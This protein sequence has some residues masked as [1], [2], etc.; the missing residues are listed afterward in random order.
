MNVNPSLFYLH[1]LLPLFMDLCR[2]D[3]GAQRVC[4]LSTYMNIYNRVLART[5]LKQGGISV[6]HI[7]GNLGACSPSNF[8]QRQAG[9]DW[10]VCFAGNSCFFPTC[11]ASLRSEPELPVDPLEVSP[12]SLR[13]CTFSICRQRDCGDTKGMCLFNFM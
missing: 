8:I 12:Q 1:R 4:G 2:S 13:L 10:H 6:Q 9:A 11:M 5:L 3:C 7:S